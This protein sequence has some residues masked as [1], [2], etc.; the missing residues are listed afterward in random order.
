MAVADEDLDVR[1]VRDALT[2]LTT[3]PAAAAI[4]AAEK[5]FA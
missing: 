1:L 5:P 4:A 3:P 2:R